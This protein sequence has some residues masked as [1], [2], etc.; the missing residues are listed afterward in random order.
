MLIGG[1]SLGTC[2]FN[3][4]SG[5]TGDIAYVI[6]S[7]AEGETDYSDEVKAAYYNN[8]TELYEFPDDFI[9]GCSGLTGTLTVPYFI[10]RIGDRAFKSC[11]GITGLTYES[12]NDKPSVLTSIGDQA[13]QYC[14]GLTSTISFPTPNASISTT[15]YITLGVRTFD[16][17]TGGAIDLTNVASLG[18]YCFNNYKGNSGGKTKGKKTFSLLNDFVVSSSW[19]GN[20]TEVHDFD[21]YE[22]WGKKT[23][24]ATSTTKLVSSGTITD[25]VNL[26]LGSTITTLPQYC[27]YNAKLDEVIGSS[28]TLETKYCAFCFSTLT[29]FNMSETGISFEENSC[30][31]HCN[32]LTT[33][34]TQNDT[35]SVTAYSFNYC[36]RLATISFAPTFVGINGF[37]QCCSLSN[38]NFENLSGTISGYAFS[39]C[40]NLSKITPSNSSDLIITLQNT[41]VNKLNIKSFYYCT[42][43]Y[44]FIYRK[45]E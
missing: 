33:F 7:L 20:Q 37:N 24:D 9:S 3:R 12:T 44:R 4:C 32:Y 41:T 5:M 22:V 39:H 31:S 23:P 1:I 36:Y 13:F 29:L 27:F 40:Y 35:I 25:V 17:A 42:R 26:N 11:S 10:Q 45:F 2:V 18:E 43:S 28:S 6:P 30:F 38:I 16:G 19:T 34:N 14:T 21:Y 15:P 8:T